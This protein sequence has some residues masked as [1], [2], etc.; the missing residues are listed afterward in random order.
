MLHHGV[1]VGFLSLA[2]IAGLALNVQTAKAHT[3]GEAKNSPASY[4]EDAALY[5]EQ[6]NG[7]PRAL[8]AAVA[9]AESGRYSPETRKTRAWPWTINAEGRPYY[10]NTKEEAIRMTRHLLDS[11]MRSIDI[12]CMQVNLRYHPDAFDSLEDGFDP[13]TN[14]AYGANFL[15]RLHS[16]SGSWQEAVANY[17]SQTTSRG[18]RYFARVIR[19]WEKEHGRVIERAAMMTPPPPRI[20]LAGALRSSIFHT[21]ELEERND[22]II[23]ASYRPAPKVLDTHPHQ[24]V[25]EAANA[26][27]GLRLSITDEG[28]EENLTTIAMIEERSVPRVLAPTSSMPTLMAEARLSDIR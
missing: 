20:D 11:G 3:K 24:N 12:G 22:E 16:R 10:F 2:L 17:H 4:C 21:N 15:L 7:L 26:I 8:L 28:L 1:K 25:R 5:H 13:H 23:T 27:V 6:M 19:I 14:V 9:L 18:S